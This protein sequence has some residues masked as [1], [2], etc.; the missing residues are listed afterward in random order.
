MR[1]LI[2]IGILNR[3][4][5]INEAI[6]LQTDFSVFIVPLLRDR[7]DKATKL[8]NGCGGGETLFLSFLLFGGSLYEKEPQKT[9]LLELDF[10][11]SC[12]CVADG[13]DKA[14]KLLDGCAA[15]VVLESCFCYF[16]CSG[17]LPIRE[18]PKS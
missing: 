8:L 12:D 15:A 16:F 2:F 5:C 14:A 13:F 17:A 3:G 18:S 7:F 11:R 4:S 9:I 1:N 6:T 10:G